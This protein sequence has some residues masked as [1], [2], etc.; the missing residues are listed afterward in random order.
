MLGTSRQDIIFVYMLKKNWNSIHNFCCYDV[1]IL[2][3]QNMR[4]LQTELLF[5]KAGPVLTKNN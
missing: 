1:I 4:A 5:S 2:D 3:F